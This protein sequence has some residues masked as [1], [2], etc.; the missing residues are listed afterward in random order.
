MRTFADDSFAKPE[1]DDAFRAE[2]KMLE[3]LIG[4]AAAIAGNS[5]PLVA[6]RVAEARVLGAT[7]A[8]IHLAGQ[9][10]LGSRKGAQEAADAGLA[11]A[12]GDD[13]N[14]GCCED[15]KA[16]T[17]GSRGEPPRR[18]RRARAP[19]RS[20]HG[21]SA[22]AVCSIR[23]QQAV[24]RCLAVTSKRRS[25]RPGNPAVATSAD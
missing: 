12:L 22:A 20:P 10:G 25:L 17:S 21:P 7:R 19:A 6:A 14:A 16:C 2:R 5:A 4:V 18:S 24:R 9:I 23:K 15:G 11:S 8:Q 1:L 13:D 3:A